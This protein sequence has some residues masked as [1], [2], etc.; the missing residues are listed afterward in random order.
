MT[1]GSG[2]LWLLA[3]PVAIAALYGLHRLA[4]RLEAQGYLYYLHKRPDS[5]AASSFV[6]LQQ[7]IDPTA[8]HIFQVQD[9]RRGRG[10]DEAT[11]DPPDA[12][13]GP[14]EGAWKCVPPAEPRIESPTI[15]PPLRS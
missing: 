2:W 5:S 6:A 7:A 8:E 1:F 14:R 13:G 10:E 11:G 15:R 3:I 4:L 12:R 9:E